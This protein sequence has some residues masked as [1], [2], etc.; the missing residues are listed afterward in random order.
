MGRHHH[1]RVN[2]RPTSTFVRR[3]AISLDDTKFDDDIPRLA[4]AIK[5]VVDRQAGESNA[6]TPNSTTSN[7]PSGQSST[8]SIGSAARPSANGLAQTN[9]LSGKAGV[10]HGPD[11]YQAAQEGLGASAAAPS[12]AASAGV[13]TANRQTIFSERASDTP[14]VRYWVGASSLGGPL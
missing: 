14:P 9:E 5:K 2:S 4:R 8:P 1:G 11:V 10:L 3:H 12:S 6:D 7:T 13:S